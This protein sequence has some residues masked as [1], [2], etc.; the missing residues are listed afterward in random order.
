MPDKN[1]RIVP[2]IHFCS[3][4]FKEPRQEVITPTTEA[5]E[6]NGDKNPIQ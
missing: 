4:A 3:A 5:M 6:A 2:I 1:E